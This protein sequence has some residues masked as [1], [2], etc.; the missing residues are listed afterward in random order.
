MAEHQHA[1]MCSVRKRAG[2]TCSRCKKGEQTFM[3][4]VVV[5]FITEHD[6]ANATEN[7]TLLRT[8]AGPGST[9]V[10]GR[11]VPCTPL[12]ARDSLGLVVYSRRRRWRAELP[13]SSASP[14]LRC[15]ELA[16]G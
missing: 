5:V 16:R 6:G 13:S 2:D 12:V 9:G 3:C 7:I 1:E 8:L 14:S 10:N 4:R 15:I 11:L